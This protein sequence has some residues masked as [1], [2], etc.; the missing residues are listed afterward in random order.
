[1][2][3]SRSGW[4]FKKQ[5][6]KSELFQADKT[7]RKDKKQKGQKTELGDKTASK[8]QIQSNIRS[9]AVYNQ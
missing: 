7:N 3:F 8:E 1:M 2:K 5:S 6:L 4:P 9:Q